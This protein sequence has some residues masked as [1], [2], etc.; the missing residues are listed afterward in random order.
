MLQ[1]IEISLVKCGEFAF[2]TVN[3][4]LWQFSLAEDHIRKDYRYENLYNVDAS[5]LPYF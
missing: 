1:E 2:E 3:F 4:Q 5:C